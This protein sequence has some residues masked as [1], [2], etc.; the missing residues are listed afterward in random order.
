VKV[1][2]VDSMISWRSSLV[3][4]GLNWNAIDTSLPFTWVQ[5]SSY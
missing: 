1:A 4:A 2:R 5:N 3:T